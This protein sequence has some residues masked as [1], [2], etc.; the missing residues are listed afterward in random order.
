MVRSQLSCFLSLMRCGCL[1]HAPEQHNRYS[2]VREKILDP[3]YDGFFLKFA[4]GG[5]SDFKNGTWHMDKCTES[6]VGN[7]QKCSD[8]YHGTRSRVVRLAGRLA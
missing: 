1:P 5:S 3:Q 4:P 6:K 2:T 8:F 7:P